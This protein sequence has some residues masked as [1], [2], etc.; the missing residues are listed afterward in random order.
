MLVL[1]KLMFFVAVGERGKDVM[2]EEVCRRCNG[3]GNKGGVAA[4][5]VQLPY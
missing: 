4:E 2:P 1:L 3:N 5:R